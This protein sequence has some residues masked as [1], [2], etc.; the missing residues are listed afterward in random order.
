MFSA[1]EQRF[2]VERGLV[3]QP[4]RCSGCRLELKNWRKAQL[5]EAPVTLAVAVCCVCSVVVKVP[6][7]PKGHKPIYCRP[8]LHKRINGAAEPAAQ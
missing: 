7:E 4:K 2:F 3:H 1:E 8:C 6:F 5:G